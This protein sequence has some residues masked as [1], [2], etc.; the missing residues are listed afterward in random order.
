MS[1]RQADDVAR[2]LNW[3]GLNSSQEPARDIQRIL[4]K[5]L[6]REFCASV[7]ENGLR[8]GKVIDVS[9]ERTIT[10]S[11]PVSM[12]QVLLPPLDEFSIVRVSGRMITDTNAHS[13]TMTCLLAGQ[14]MCSSTLTSAGAIVQPFSF[15][16]VNRGSKQQQSC[17]PSFSNPSATG[18]A[19]VSRN[20][21]TS[22]PTLLEVVGTVA[23]YSMTLEHLLVQ[24]L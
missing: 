20:V 3:L 15:D 14:Q 17:H 7:I 12:G 2:G 24:I 4:S 21:D 22:V 5:F 9:G 6:E 10:N 1:G 18:S 13:R 8:A 23:T 16:I 11:G 19:L